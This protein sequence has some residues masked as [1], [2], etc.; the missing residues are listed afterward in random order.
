MSGRVGAVE[1]LP[2][3]ELYSDHGENEE[4][5]NVDDQDVEHIFE[6][7]N[8]AVKHSLDDTNI[9]GSITQSPFY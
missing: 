5:K 4:E 9:Q 8:N 1:K 7:G 3:E 2:V 6:G